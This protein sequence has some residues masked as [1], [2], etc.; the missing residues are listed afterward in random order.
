MRENRL[1]VQRGMKPKNDGTGTSEEKI[2][3]YKETRVREGLNNKSNRGQSLPLGQ[4]LSELGWGYAG[5]NTASEDSSAV[6]SAG[7]AGELLELA[8]AS[9]SFD[10][11][12]C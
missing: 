1:I 10:S 2:N 9:R 3:Q 5:L 12:G 4:L 11:L 6:L 7:Q 8:S